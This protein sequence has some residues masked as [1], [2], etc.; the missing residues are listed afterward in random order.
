MGKQ[1]GDAYPDPRETYSG[2]RKVKA[3]ACISLLLLCLGSFVTAVSAPD[4]LPD[5]RIGSIPIFERHL[6][7]GIPVVNPIMKPQIVYT[8]E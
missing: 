6:N 7:I 5:P 8:I 4:S 3:L 1:K 2:K